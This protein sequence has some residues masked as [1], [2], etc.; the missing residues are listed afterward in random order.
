LNA[1]C[2][3]DY[4]INGSVF[5]K[6]YPKQINFSIDDLLLLNELRQGTSPLERFQ[7]NLRRLIEK[8]IIE[9]FGRGKGTKYILTKKYYSFVGQKGIYTRRRGLENVEKKELILKHL[10]IH[11]KGNMEEF[12]QIFPTLTR[13]QIHTLLKSL[14]V[15]ELIRYT[16][17][18]KT[19]HWVLTR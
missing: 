2:H 1:V 18:P 5:I 8:G 4:Q 11:Q 7:E 9:V 13:Y 17:A 6:Q 3:R 16:G 12:Q 14:K 19:G 15:K 10:R